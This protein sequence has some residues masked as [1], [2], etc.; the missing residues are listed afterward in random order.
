MIRYSSSISHPNVQRSGNLNC[1]NID[2]KMIVQ[3]SFHILTVSLLFFP[4]QSF[5]CDSS[6]PD[7]CPPNGSSPTNIGGVSGCSNYTGPLP[8]NSNFSTLRSQFINDIFGTP[9]L[10]TTI[11]PDYIENINTPQAS[12]CWCTTQGNCNITECMWNNNM[13]K[14]TFTISVPVN[15]SFSITANSTVF[16]TL[17][18]S[19]V[20]PI[21]YPPISPPG[22]PDELLPP[23]KLGKVLVLMHEGHDD[24][25][26]TCFADYDGT[27]DFLNQL[28][29]D[30]MYFH[31]PGWGCSP[32]DLPGYSCS[33]GHA[34][35]QPYADQGAKV[36]RLFL[37]PV[38]RAINYATEVLGYQQI[39][40]MGL[41][42]GGWTTTMMGALDTRI[43]VSIPIAGSVPCDFAHTSWDF[44]QLCDQPWFQTVNYTNIY[45]LAANEPNRASIQILHEADP[46]CFHACHRHDRIRTYN[47]YV[48][49]T[50]QGAFGTVA[51]VG[52]AHEVNIRDKMVVGS[53]LDKYRVNG[54]ITQ[55]DINN[56]PYNTLKEW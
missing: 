28:G 51:T 44:E 50:A 43:G 1:K 33:Q 40:M 29:Y 3:F 32:L 8:S 16:Y 56:L 10:P 27:V 38:V 2:R 41:S 36:I 53:I 30:V 22:F 52:N 13:T 24:D 15:S 47:Q 19:G 46:C 5:V 25:C 48:Q 49:H 20:A 18:T 54:I 37:E 11:Y 35:L 45:V 9:T 26:A 55:T 42:G 39:V 6:W 7:Y 23:L 21:E 17:N 4:V 14:L 12:G 31:M 34:P